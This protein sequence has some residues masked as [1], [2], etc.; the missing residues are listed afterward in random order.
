MDFGALLADAFTL[1]ALATLALLVGLELV[2]GIDNVLV[3][4]IVVSRAPGRKLTNCLV[5]VST[6]Q[7]RKGCDGGDTAA[8]PP[9]DMVAA[10]TSPSV[11]CSNPRPF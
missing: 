2:L 7:R 6:H 5:S 9:D 1:N 3:I 8:T 4:S 11:P 10:A